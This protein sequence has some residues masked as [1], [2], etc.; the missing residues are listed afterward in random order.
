M[1]NPRKLLGI[2]NQLILYLVENGLKPSGS[3]DLEDL[4]YYFTEY[5]KLEED[6]KNNIKIITSNIKSSL[7]DNFSRFLDSLNIVHKYEE[8][9]SLYNSRMYNNIVLEIKNNKIPVFYIAKSNQNLERLTNAKT[10]KEKGLAFGFPKEAVDSY[11]KV[12]DGERRDGTYFAVSL[13]RAKK[14]GVDIPSWLAYVN[15]VPGQLDLVNGNISTS[16]FELAT[17]YQRFVRE[18]N[19]ELAKLVEEEF[20]QRDIPVK[21]EKMPDFSYSCGI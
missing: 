21:W 1:N 14:A 5:T 12:I 3:I 15:Y 7:I 6:F 16:T 10:P 2:S 20:F 17:K 8:S 11:N 4:H 19:S 13:G 18:N 9:I